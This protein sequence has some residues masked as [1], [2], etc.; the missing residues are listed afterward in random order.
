M[1]LR[2][3]SQRPRMNHYLHPH[4]S[5]Q[6]ARRTQMA[7]AA[8]RINSVATAVVIASDCAPEYRPRISPCCS[9]IATCAAPAA[10][11][12]AAN[13]AESASKPIGT[14]ANT[15]GATAAAVAPVSAAN[16][17]C[18]E[19]ANPTTSGTIANVMIYLLEGS[20]D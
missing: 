19:A 1:G 4:T 5:T 2:R 11:A 3:R 7:V 14:G 18:V 15:A 13:F 12:I 9:A 17:D 10:A 16:P 6:P 8:A 20:K